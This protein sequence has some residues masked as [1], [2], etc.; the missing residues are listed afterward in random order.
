MGNLNNGTFDVG[1]SFLGITVQQGDPVVLNY[2][3]FNSGNSSANEVELTMTTVGI[4]LASELDSS[5]AQFT[6]SL[7]DVAAQFAAEFKLIITP[8]SCDGLVAAEQDVFTYAQLLDDLSNFTQTTR[9]T[10]AKS[11]SGCN[12]RPSTYLVH[13]CVAQI[14]DI[15]VSSV[16]DLGK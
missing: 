7:A 1:L 15:F 16:T 13:W 8:G 9:H 14:V 4:Q 2:L 11:P 10:G 12:S 6:S 3:I 5:P